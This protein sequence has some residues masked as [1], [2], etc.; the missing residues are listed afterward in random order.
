MSN[1]LIIHLPSL[2]Y[3]E[4]KQ[5]VNMNKTLHQIIVRLLDYITNTGS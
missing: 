2:K 5:T 1:L 3:H 4:Y